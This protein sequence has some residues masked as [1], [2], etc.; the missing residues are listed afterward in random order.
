M[1]RGIVGSSLRAE[2]AS[3]GLGVRDSLWSL[4]LVWPWMWLAPGGAGRD[5]III[6]PS[7]GQQHGR[8]FSGQCSGR[9]CSLWLMKRTV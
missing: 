3:R 7:G 9:T 8:R 6:L 1:P 5:T 4:V 2:Y